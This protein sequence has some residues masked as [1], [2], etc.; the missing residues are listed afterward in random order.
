MSRIKN[1]LILEHF[2]NNQFD[3]P[4]TFGKYWFEFEGLRERRKMLVI[5]QNDE[6]KT[7][8]NYIGEPIKNCLGDIREDVIDELKVEIEKQIKR[9]DE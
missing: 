6:W 1:L 9:M 5:R 7:V 3:T 4:Y 2:T 8:S